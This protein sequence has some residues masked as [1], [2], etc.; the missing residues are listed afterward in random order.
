MLRV[1]IGT[2]DLTPGTSD[3]QS[4]DMGSAVQIGALVPAKNRTPEKFVPHTVAE[5]I[6]C[7]AIRGVEHGVL[8]EEFST[9]DASNGITV[10]VKAAMGQIGK[11]K[12]VTPRG[13]PVY[14]LNPV[15]VTKIQRDGGRAV[16]VG[17]EAGP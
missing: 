1:L 14:I 6:P 8:H 4:F 9:H 12:F 5:T 16:R 3:A 13:E 15:P 7:M 11:S 10:S 17:R 2:T